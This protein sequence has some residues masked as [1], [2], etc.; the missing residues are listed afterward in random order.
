MRSGRYQ[1]T[2]T[3]K[4]SDDPLVKLMRGILKDEQ[5]SL[6]NEFR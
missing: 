6:R 4:K 1:S 2:A 3:E 5:A